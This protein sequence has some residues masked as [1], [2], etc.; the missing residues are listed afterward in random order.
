MDFTQDF[1]KDD[2]VGSKALDPPLLQ[3]KVSRKTSLLDN[4][5]QR[6]CFPADSI[7]VGHATQT[8]DEC[9]LGQAPG[10]SGIVTGSEHLVWK[11]PQC[12]TTNSV[13][14]VECGNCGSDRN[15][16]DR[17]TPKRSTGGRSHG[18]LGDRATAGHLDQAKEIDN[19]RAQVKMLT[20]QSLKRERRF[21]LVQAQLARALQ[22]SEPLPVA[23]LTEPRQGTDNATGPSELQNVYLS[24]LDLYET[25]TTGEALTL[26]TIS[27][28]KA[29]Q[30]IS[31]INKM[32]TF[33]PEGY[34]ALVS[35]A[36]CQVIMLL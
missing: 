8:R 18:L 6:R 4:Q 5:N 27:K 31:K 21:E 30:F 1:V 29:V 15:N 36:C 14:N 23:D 7:S 9:L 20:E 12:H 26:H 25:A 13:I 32:F 22:Q 11:C 24:S 34:D 17:K 10:Q 28:L 35:V 3:D 33:E 2:K 19:L 16:G